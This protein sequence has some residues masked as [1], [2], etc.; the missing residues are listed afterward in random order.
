MKHLLLQADARKIPLADKS[1]HCVVTSP[2]YFNLRDYEVAGQIG[3]EETP[4][5]YVDVM[6]AIFKEVW[7]VL[8]DDGV[9]FLNVGDTYQNGKGK[10]HGT[11]PKN[12]HAR[13]LGLRPV[14]G[15]IPG[16]KNK[17]LI[18][19]PWTL[20]FRLRDEGWHLR[21]DCIWSKPNP[22]RESVTDRPTKSHEYLFLLS[23]KP[24]YYYD[25]FALREKRKTSSF[26]RGNVDP[27]QL[28]GTK[29]HKGGNSQFRDAGTR[30]W[31]DSGGANKLS[32]WT[33]PTHPLKD[34]H[35]ATMPVKLAMPCIQAGTS[36]K[37]C[38]PKCGSQWTR[39]VK[40]ERVPTRPGVES[41]VYATAPL[42][43]DSPHL[44]HYGDICGNR[45]PR[46]HVTHVQTV[47][48]ESSCTCLEAKHPVPSRVFDPFGG[49]MTTVLA[50]DMLG[51]IGIATELK[52]GYIEIG[53]RRLERPHAP[54]SKKKPRN[55]ESYPLFREQST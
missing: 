55:K 40:K 7:R 14:D 3:L 54:A 4:Q 34:A 21:S 11:D 50:A 38:C 46:R 45:D 23:K 10:A 12:V 35:F 19:I 6:A 33:V 2:P 16:L 9:V 51:R 39:V 20:A 37:G 26:F 29:E 49:A 31:G 18:G 36:E 43:P 25:R 30:A 53:R 8:R 48:W 42:H 13:S 27:G 52:P 28:Q 15:R 5:A 32:V 17:D 22:M 47:G 44:A 24:R 1:V 41:K